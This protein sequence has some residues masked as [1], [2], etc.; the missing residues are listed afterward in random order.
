LNPSIDIS[1]GEVVAIAAAI[2]QAVATIA[3]VL[4]TKGYAKKTGELAEQGKKIV[5]LRMTPGVGL[6]ARLMTDAELNNVRPYAQGKI[7]VKLKFVNLGEYPILKVVPHLLVIEE[8]DN[9]GSNVFF[10]YIKPSKSK[11]ICPVFSFKEGKNG[12]SEV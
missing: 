10:Q 4:I 5:A 11:T 8:K 7:G 9:I 2:V 1:S 6:S 12:I 3:L